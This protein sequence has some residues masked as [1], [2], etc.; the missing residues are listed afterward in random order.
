MFRQNQKTAHKLAKILET[1]ID[2]NEALRV[3]VGITNKNIRD[4]EFKKINKLGL[5][6]NE[7]HLGGI[8]RDG[9]DIVDSINVS[10]KRKSSRPAIL[11]GI[12]SCQV[13]LFGFELL[14][15]GLNS[16]RP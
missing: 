8:R 7:I 6:V 14:Y 2:Y 13:I 9:I 15:L 4:V 11:I 3:F 10:F 12:L 1:H 5:V 16:Y